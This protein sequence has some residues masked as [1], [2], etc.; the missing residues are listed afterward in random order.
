[1]ARYGADALTRRNAA[2]AVLGQHTH[3]VHDELVDRQ[4]PLQLGVY[5]HRAIS[6][7]GR[8]AAWQS[9]GAV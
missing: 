4:R 1:V 6:H 2:T 5:A 3:P 9:S 7:N 8:F